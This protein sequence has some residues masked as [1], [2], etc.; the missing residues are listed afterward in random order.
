MSGFS[1]EWLALREPVDHASINHTVREC[2]RRHFA[3]RQSIKIVDFGSGTGSNLRS[4]APDLAVVQ[5]WTL[6]DIDEALLQQVASRSAECI[7]G[8]ANGVSFTCATADL[9]EADLDDIIDGCDLVT[10]SALFDLVSHDVIDRVTQATAAHDAAFYTTLVYDG[11]A[12]WI[13]EHPADTQMRQAFNAHQRTDK[14]LG[15]A[16]GPDASAALTTAFRNQGYAVTTGKSPWI[17]DNSVERLRLEADRGWAGA[18]AETDMLAAED[19]ESWL[20]HRQQPTNA[21]TIVGPRRRA[22]TA[23]AALRT[24]AMQGISQ[25]IGVFGRP[26]A[27]QHVVA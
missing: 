15:I 20:S 6:I 23:A 25:L 5:S 13:P 7:A 19:V 24:R 12:A 2:L 26:H 11:I 16:A 4:L 9:A 8:I 10:A 27:S 22:G 3:G 14:G 1:A 21:I 18:V 17:M